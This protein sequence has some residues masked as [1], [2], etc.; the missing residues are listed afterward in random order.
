MTGFV[1]EKKK[2]KGDFHSNIV[3]RRT[4]SKIRKSPA[5]VPLESRAVEM[6][7]RQQVLAECLHPALS[8]QRPTT[9]RV[10]RQ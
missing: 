8:L 2:K 10:K 7:M 1:F 4:S 9:T 5:G 6:A 3:A